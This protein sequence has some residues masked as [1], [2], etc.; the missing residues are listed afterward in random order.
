MNLSDLY[1]LNLI[2][3]KLR[4]RVKNLDLFRFHDKNALI[5]RQFEFRQLFLN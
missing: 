4:R 3:S 2:L 1:N 5:C